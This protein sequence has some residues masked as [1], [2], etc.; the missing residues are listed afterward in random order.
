MFPL[1]CQRYPSPAVTSP[2]PPVT[3]HNNPHRVTST[4]LRNFFHKLYYYVGW[5]YFPCLHYFLEF[6]YFTLKCWVFH[7]SVP[8]LLSKCSCAEV[9]AYVHVCYIF[10]Y[11]LVVYLLVCLYLFVSLKY[12]Y[13]LLFFYG[14]C[15]ILA[16]QLLSWA[17]CSPPAVNPSSLT[18]AFPP[19]AALCG[20][21]SSSGWICLSWAR[22]ADLRCR[23]RDTTALAWVTTLHDRPL[24]C[25]RGRVLSSREG[26]IAVEGGMVG[27]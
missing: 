7:I 16:H 22:G 19:P 24:R 12:M 5:L 2:F 26:Q 17:H 13:H 27:S 21:A 20:G 11:L 14:C 10:V 23:A 6:P 4:I 15:M 1:G 18:C 9:G 25:G 8:L 3:T